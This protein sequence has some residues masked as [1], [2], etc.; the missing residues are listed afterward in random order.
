MRCGVGFVFLILARSR[1]AMRPA[2]VHLLSGLQLRMSRVRQTPWESAEA[3]EITLPERVS[4]GEEALI[5]ASHFAWF[6]AAKVRDEKY[7]EASG[8]Q[9]SVQILIAR[10][11]LPDHCQSAN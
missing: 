6:T 5:S 7:M 4:V 8:C 1:I 10:T 2:R 11:M 9:V 3:I